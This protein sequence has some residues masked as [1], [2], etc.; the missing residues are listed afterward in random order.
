M[1]PTNTKPAV[2][3]ISFCRYVNAVVVILFSL[4]FFLIPGLTVV[5]DLSDPNIRSAGIPQSAWKLHQTLSPK[6]E[7]WA[8]ERLDST[9]A[10]ELSTANV[11]GTE[12]PLFGSVFYLWATE[13]LQDAWEKDHSTTLVA[14]NIYAKDAI[15]A[16]TCLVIDPKQANW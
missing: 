11:S 4:F 10:A 9:R 3:P 5:H 2:F 13:S 8:R 14:P 12:W 6:F 16:A 15:E 1:H 7:K